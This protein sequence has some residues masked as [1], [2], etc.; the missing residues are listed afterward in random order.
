MLSRLSRTK[1]VGVLTALAVGIAMFAFSGGAMASDKLILKDGRVVE[2]T[3]TREGDEFVYITTKIGSIEKQEFFTK[4]QI[5]KIDRE[6]DAK[7][8]ADAAKAD[9]K[10]ASEAGSGGKS[11]A[12]RV[13][14]LNFGPPSSW[15][16][17]VGNMVGVQI[18]EQAFEEV[19]PMLKKDKVDVVVIRVN[20]GGGLA[21]EVPKFHKLFI[22][23]YRPNFRTVGWIESAIS[24]A[25]MSPYVLEELYFMPEGNFGACTMFSGALVAAKDMSLEWVL[26]LME[27]ASGAVGRDPHIMRS[28]QIMD[29]LSVTKDENGAVHWYPDTSGRRVLNPPGQ[30]LTFN[31]TDALEYKFSRGTASTVDE[32]CKAMG[33]QEYEIVGDDATRYIDEFMKRSD[34]M[35][36]EFSM[37]LSKYG[38][39]VSTARQV[40]DKTQRGAEVGRAR[41]LL[42]EIEVDVKKNANFEFMN[43]IG[44]QLNREWFMLQ[45]EMLK[46]LMR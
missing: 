31:S 34:A 30:I 44:R 28:M 43:P 25:A 29:P 27:K 6:A 26:D 13:C 40:Q 7:P 14:I 46:E 37:R 3:I 1:F 4:D 8:K 16:G 20:S 11:G 15:M 41:R 23:Q 12:T 45:R 2:G 33:L 24:A 38:L 42:D 35:E 39:A 36:K 10:P 17:K 5:T 9:T 32:L 22:D 18:A 21:A 19:V